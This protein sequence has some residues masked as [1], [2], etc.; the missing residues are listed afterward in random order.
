MGYK[1][2]SE[3]KRA[4]NEVVFKQQNE[5]IK[6]QTSRLLP[7]EDKAT[8]P[9]NFTCECADENCREQV[10]LTIVQFNRNSKNS[11]HFIIRPGHE[12]PDV[13]HVIEMGEGFNVV[14]KFE[15]PP[16]TDGVLNRTTAENS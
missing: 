15:E 2:Q 6:R 11:K 16:S 5:S 7:H 13:E 12:Q 14:E 1:K 10:Q 4:E 3:L 8:F 9:V